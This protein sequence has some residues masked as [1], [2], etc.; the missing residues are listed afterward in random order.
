MCNH[1]S[2]WPYNLRQTMATWPRCHYLWVFECLFV[3]DGK[4]VKLVPIRPVPPPDTKP[5]DISSSKKTLNLISQKSLNKESLENLLWCL[6]GAN[7]RN[8]DL[9]L[10]TAE[11]THDSSINRSRGMNP[12]EVMHG[13]KPKKPIN[14]ILEYPNLHLHLYRMFMIYIKRSARK[15]KKVMHIINLMLICTASILKLMRVIP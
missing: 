2:C 3:R 12:V 6:V 13:Y 8:W 4:K 14:H 9:I 7:L 5:S 10:P 1:H 15:F 11:F